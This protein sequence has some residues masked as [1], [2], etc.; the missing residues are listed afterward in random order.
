M[1]SKE[2]LEDCGEVR[3]RDSEPFLVEVGFGLVKEVLMSNKLF[4][5]LP[6]GVEGSPLLKSE[7]EV[8]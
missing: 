8:M 2:E 4:L 1:E 7:V 3:S 5:P 6:C